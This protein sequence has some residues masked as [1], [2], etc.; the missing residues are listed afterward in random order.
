MRRIVGLLVA[1]TATVAVAG[2]S[3]Q[4]TPHAD[5]RATVVDDASG[6]SGGSS[7]AL[8]PPPADYKTMT[9]TTYRAQPDP[10]QQSVVH[11]ILGPDK[12]NYILI[13]TLVDIMCLR[14]PNAAVVD[15]LSSIRPD[16]IR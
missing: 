11:A 12:K 3:V 8:P 2:C 13:S 4:G 14:Q 5:P 10:V 9:C 15:V 1:A 6:Y 7:E 16:F